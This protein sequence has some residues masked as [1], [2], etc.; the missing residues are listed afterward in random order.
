MPSTAGQYSSWQAKTTLDEKSGVGPALICGAGRLMLAWTGTDGRLNFQF[1]GD[2]KNWFGKKTLSERCPT[3][4]SLSY[5]NGKFFL[6]WNGTDR[7]RR[8]NLMAFDK[9]GNQVL[10]K[11]TYSESSNYRPALVFDGDGRGRFSWVGRGNLQINEALLSGSFDL[12]YKRTFDDTAPNGPAL[13]LHNDTVFITWA[14]TGGTPDLNV[15]EL[16]RG[17]I[18]LYG[19]LPPHSMMVAKSDL[20]SSQQRRK[21]S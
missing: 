20:R 18:S 14:G 7:E 3:E 4:P 8:L 2:G 10:T 19:E 21:L 9:D 6:L 11:K 1:S 16:S 5:Y 13:C 12:E 17:G 15:A